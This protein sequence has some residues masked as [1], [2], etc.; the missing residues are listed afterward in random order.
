M[1]NSFTQRIMRFIAAL[2]GVVMLAG[3]LAKDFGIDP[4]RTKAM[5]TFV[6]APK[7]VDGNATTHTGECT[8]RNGPISK[9]EAAE[10]MEDPTLIVTRNMCIEFDDKKT[11]ALAQLA[12][13]GGQQVA[14]KIVENTAAAATGGLVNLFVQKVLQHEQGKICKD[15][16]CI[17]TVNNNVAFGGQ[18][19]QGGQGGVGQGGAAVSV[20]EAGAAAVTDVR[21]EGTGGGCGSGGTCGS[22]K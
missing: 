19:G 14:G 10:L 1:N 11:R 8:F 6:V 2:I 5:A 9:A 15:G 16:G 21:I 12:V 22:V 3:C 20:S 18:G 13:Q 7:T 4:T 17:N